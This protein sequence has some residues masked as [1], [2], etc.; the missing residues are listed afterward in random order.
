MRLPVLILIIICLLVVAGIIYVFSG[1]Y[2]ISATHPHWD[3]TV[4]M[5]DQIREQS[6]EFHSK[7][8]K[9]RDLKDEKLLKVGIQH[10]HEMC[11]LCHGAP[12]QEKEEFATG[13]YPKPPDLASKEIQKEMSDAETFWV[14]KNGIKMTGMPAFGPTHDD[15]ELW[16]I[17][18]FW[19]R[20]PG[21][22]PEQ[23]KEYLESAGVHGEKGEHNHDAEKAGHNQQH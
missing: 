7:G 20:L 12:G 1:Y 8:I 3:T 2:D 21:M 6:I 17:V 16:G 9:P 13:L 4:W 22:K 14:L 18:A 11:R 23:Y 10:Y 15:D 5:I 19:R